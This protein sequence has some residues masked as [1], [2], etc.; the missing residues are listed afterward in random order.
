M[1]VGY[2]QGMG[3]LAGLLLLVIREEQQAFWAL[4]ALLR[5][6]RHPPMAGLFYQGLPLLQ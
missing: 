4:A 1:Q 2:V 6:Y 5:G 3:F